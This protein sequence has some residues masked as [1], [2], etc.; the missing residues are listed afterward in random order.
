MKTE[1]AFG[2]SAVSTL[3]F[4]CCKA[5]LAACPYTG[6]APVFPPSPRVATTPGEMRNEAAF[7]EQRSGTLKRADEW[8]QNPPTIPSEYGGWIFDYACPKDAQRLVAVSE[9][10]HR[11]PQC[12]QLFG[13]E[14]IVAAYRGS[15]HNKLNQAALDLGW[16]YLYS[17]RRGKT[18]PHRAGR[19]VFD[20]S[21]PARPLGTHRLFGHSGRTPLCAKP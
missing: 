4:I 3:L 20:L 15:L 17:N 14:R 2:K 1:T 16:A 12:G 18:N 7:Q 21:E 13:D 10:Q 5:V 8:L 6:P 11:C 19:C 9:Q